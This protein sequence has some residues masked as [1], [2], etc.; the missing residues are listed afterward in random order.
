MDRFGGVLCGGNHRSEDPAQVGDIEAGTK[1]L[2]EALQAPQLGAV[3]LGRLLPELL[4]IGRQ[5]GCGRR[6]FSG[7]RRD[8]DLGPPKRPTRVSLIQAGPWARKD[9]DNLRDE[10]E[11]MCAWGM[12]EI[13]DRISEGRGRPA[14]S[15]RHRQHPY[16][17][18]FEAAADLGGGGSR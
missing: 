9:P 3:E 14:Q 1:I 17:R 8:L 5:R 11:R 16:S 15:Y 10:V 4:P 2:V 13:G 18:V 7:P 12:L 6:R